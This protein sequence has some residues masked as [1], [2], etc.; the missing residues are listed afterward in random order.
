[1]NIL[2]TQVSVPYA[3]A[4]AL[5]ALLC[6]LTV[7][8]V[9][10]REIAIR[11]IVGPRSP[12]WI[13]GHMLQLMLP[14]P[15]GDHESQWQKQFGS[16]YHLKGCFG[17]DRL[18]V[19]DP[20]ALQHM[21]NSPMFVRGGMLAV[22]MDL[23]YGEK[24]VVN[25][26][27]DE[28]RRIRG[29]LNVGFTAS[30]VR[31]YQPVFEKAAETISEQ[32]ENSPATSTNICPVLS[33]ATLGVVSEAVLR[34][35]IQDLGEDFV[36]NNIQLLELAATQ[37][38]SE[39]LVDALGVWFPLRLWRAAMYL[40]I[41]TFKMFREHKYLANQIGRRAVEDR[42]NATRQGLETTDDLFSL[43]LNPDTS[44]SLNEDEIVEQTNLVL[45]AGQETTANTI[46]FGLLELARHPDFQEKL[47]AEVHS[48]LGTSSAPVSYDSM[49]LLNAFIKETIRLYP[50]LP[51]TDR[52]A[53]QDTTITLAEAITT[54]TGERVNQ[55]PILKGQLVT[56]AIASYQRLES[57]WGTDARE[58]NPSR[59]L[60]GTVYRG[61][62]TGPYA[63]LLSFLGGPRTCL[64]W[65]FALLEL[66]VIL[67][68]LVAK[69][70]FAEVEGESIKPQ[71][72]N[73][74]L[75]IVS[76]GDKALPLCITRL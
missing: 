65:R 8:S 43:L 10:R 58:F 32:L 20:V 67:S 5:G 29:A 17:Q 47:R 52:V 45:L 22:L 50:A 72:L 62:A 6:I 38:K 76:S 31:K 37:S 25:A 60:D 49:P 4:L 75:P 46:A 42:L 36:A 34:Y 71:L 57:R 51:L 53:L 63:N 12:S 40:P 21:L 27:G 69:F 64:G 23:V 39:I 74:L 28:H 66:Q 7:H 54:S 68:R 15:Y 2:Q 1:M 33:I 73:N 30:A 44:S 3:I 18:M 13:F 59:W 16:V 26:K 48:A 41:P 55:I 14:R 35:S 24:S 19:A 61:D 56:L 70:S 9:V 11:H